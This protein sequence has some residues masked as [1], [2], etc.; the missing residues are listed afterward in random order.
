MLE[1]EEYCDPKGRVPFAEWLEGLRDAPSR[2][3]ILKRL[4]RLRNGLWG[5]V[6]PLGEGV[7]ELREDHG[8]GFRIYVAG[9]GKALVVLLAGGDKATQRKDIE[10]AKRYWQDWK[11]RSGE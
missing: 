5:D 1:L 8:P 6:K 11:A 9:H 2:A 4:N 7:S 3:R 10:H